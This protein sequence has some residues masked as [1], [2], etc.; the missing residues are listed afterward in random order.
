[1][2]AN[3]NGDI[4]RENSMIITY[5]SH[6]FWWLDYAWFDYLSHYNVAAMGIC[7]NAWNASA[8]MYIMNIWLFYYILGLALART[9]KKMCVLHIHKYRNI[10]RSVWMHYTLGCILVDGK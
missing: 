2:S 7:A 8:R 5:L 3:K 10:T 4:W 1:M 9:K 6:S